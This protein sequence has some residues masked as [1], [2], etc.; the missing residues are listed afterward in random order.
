[1]VME[2]NMAK[3][4]VLILLGGQWHDFEGFAAAWRAILE[5]KGCS[6]KV[7]Y[8]FEALT[9][10][11]ELNC[12]LLLSYTCLTEPPVGAKPGSP[13][14]FSDAQ[15]KALVGWVQ[16]GGALLAAHAATV[17]GDSDPA[18]ERL[19]GGAFVR[20]PPQSTFTVLPLSAHHPI[21]EGIEAFD[22]YDELYIERYHP[23]VMV[24]MIAVFE[25]IA[26]PMAWSKREGQGRVA[27]I[28]LGHSDRVWE[29]EPYQRLMFQ[30][31][32]WLLKG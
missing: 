2:D 1:M 30:T 17:I 29:L 28:A 22:V 12:D 19:M 4:N 18:L 11:K 8:D 26:Y 16:R 20:H 27:H 25:Q 9:H 15:T 14:K 23:S 5:G 6:I 24:H 3:T 31:I 7:T 21:T 10:I 13:T 32:Q